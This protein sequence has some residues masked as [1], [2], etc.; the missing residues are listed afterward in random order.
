MSPLTLAGLRDRCGGLSPDP[1]LVCQVDVLDA[2][3]LQEGYYPILQLRLTFE[4]EL[5]S[6]LQTI[7]GSSRFPRARVP[8]IAAQR[9]TIWLTSL[10]C[11]SI[12][13]CPVIVPPCTELA[14]VSLLSA[15]HLLNTYSETEHAWC[16]PTHFAMAQRADAA[17]ARNKYFHNTV[18]HQSIRRAK[19]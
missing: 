10:H 14:C 18:Y 15:T 11:Q 7:A 17:A 8:G 16:L 13:T 6:P 4:E 19:S 2:T 9:P 12:C 3:L 5:Q 1:H